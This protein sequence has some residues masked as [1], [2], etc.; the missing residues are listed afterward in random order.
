M[1]RVLAGKDANGELNFYN[2][3]F[4]G[5]QPFYVEGDLGP[6]PQP[7]P[8]TPFG[9]Y[10]HSSLSKPAS[11][12]SPQPGPHS[13]VGDYHHSSPSKPASTPPSFRESENASMAAL[14][15]YNAERTDKSERNSLEARDERNAAAARADAQ[16][17]RSLEARDQ[18]NT[19][20]AAVKSAPPSFRE[21][22]NA[23]MAALSRYNAERTDKSARNS[24]EARD[25]RNAAAAR[26]GRASLTFA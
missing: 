10:H 23:S 1:G 13:P 18:R 24:L 21:S 8:H 19:E 3:V 17:S 12:P 20:R 2:S 6:S 16:A 5:R 14:S 15:R 7:G 11:T 9:D 26:G 22:E 25:E 4:V